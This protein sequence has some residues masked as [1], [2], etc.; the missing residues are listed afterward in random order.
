MTNGIAFLIMATLT[1]SCFAVSSSSK[2]VA[3]QP[4]WMVLNQISKGNGRLVQDTIDPEEE[5]MIDPS[6]ARRI[7][8][9]KRYISYNAM[10]KNN[11][12][13]NQRGKS[14]YDCNR[15]G[16]ANPY[17]RGCNVITRYKKL[18]LLLLV[19]IILWETIVDLFI[20]L[21]GAVVFLSDEILPLLLLLP[22]QREPFVAT[23]LM[24]VLVTLNS[25]MSYDDS[26][27]M[28]LP[29]SLCSLLSL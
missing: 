14:Y 6:G 15:K 21:M 29:F 27:V 7:L 3:F 20:L 16:Q 18:L 11:I 28:L 2:N 22:D 9:G 23:A 26:R 4:N 5:I 12:P 13:C 1:F 8:A 25:R 19:A 17:T 10:A 24:L